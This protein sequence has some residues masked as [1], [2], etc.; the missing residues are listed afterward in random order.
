MTELEEKIKACL[1]PDSKDSTPEKYR[2]KYDEQQQ[3]IQALQEKLELQTK[4]QEEKLNQ[5]GADVRNEVHREVSRKAKEVIADTAS[6]I[7][8]GSSSSSSKRSSSSANTV[9]TNKSSASN[10]RIENRLE[11][12]DVKLK[13]VRDKIA[14][15]KKQQD[16]IRA[17]R[18]GLAGI[19]MSGIP[20][21]VQH[22][23]RD[24][25]AAEKEER[26]LEQE[27]EARL[28]SVVNKESVKHATKVESIPQAD[29]FA[30]INAT[31]TTTEKQRGGGVNVKVGGIGGGVDV[32]SKTKKTTQQGK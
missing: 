30:E 14:G 23:E 3:Q 12:I 4:I 6:Q 29:A 9:E 18:R 5:L 31:T 11:K 22:I 20:I 13:A 27:R 28:G 8:I 25:E 10:Q 26:D 15:L 21:E 7:A 1:V 32:V 16:T 17:G 19:P 24:I 2:E